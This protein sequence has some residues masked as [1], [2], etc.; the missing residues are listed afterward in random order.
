M[1]LISIH[2]QRN[3]FFLNEIGSY[4]TRQSLIDPKPQQTLRKMVAVIETIEYHN[5]IIILSHHVTLARLEEDRRI[6]AVHLLPVVVAGVDVAAW[7][8]VAQ[9]QLLQPVVAEP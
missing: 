9:R 5:R 8:V 1:F 7:L 6:V 2:P 3:A 4:R